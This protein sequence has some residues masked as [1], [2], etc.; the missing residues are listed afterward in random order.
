VLDVV[1]VGPEELRCGHSRNVVV[2]R[3]ASASESD[4]RRRPRPAQ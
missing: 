4:G 3:L 2:L 1:R